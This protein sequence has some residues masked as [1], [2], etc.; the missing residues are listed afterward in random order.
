MTWQEINKDAAQW[1]NIQGNLC[2]FKLFNKN[3][4]KFM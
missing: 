1:Q 4:R 3:I 2:S